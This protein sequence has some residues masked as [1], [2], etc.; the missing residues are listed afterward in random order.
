M[1]AGKGRPTSLTP[2]VRDTV[3][4]KLRDCSSRE[5]A[6]ST[7]GVTSRSL[8]NWVNRGEEAFTTGGKLAIKDKIYIDFFLA[9][10]KAEAD[11]EARLLSNIIDGV[12]NWQASAWWLERRF[13][14]VW[15]ATTRHELSG[16]D[17]SAMQ[18]QAKVSMGLS[19]QTTEVIRAE[20][21]GIGK[22]DVPDDEEEG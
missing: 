8:S 11:A 20:F 15:G 17:G 7:A 4:R 21:L 10:K 2:H 19:P 6:A 14:Q 16:P 13:P 5:A 9:I 22:E 12:K 1:P 3:A 18:T